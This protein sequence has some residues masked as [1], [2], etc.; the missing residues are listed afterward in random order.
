MK[1]LEKEFNQYL[2]NL[3]IWTAKLHNLHWN[4][5]GSLFPAVHEYT[6]VLYNKTFQQMDE[7]AEHFKMFGLIPESTM[8]KY[9]EI[10]KIKEEPS[11]KFE[12]KEVLE[13]ILK[14]MELMRDEATEL[15]NACDK[16]GWFLAVSIFEEHIAGYNK[17][18]WFIK[19]TL[20]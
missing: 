2:A 5:E 7:V 1:K 17:E 6:D 18:I 9:L 19:A 20:S 14:D 13:I 3:A 4:V 11:R 10:A 8:K 15:R 16:E 12:C